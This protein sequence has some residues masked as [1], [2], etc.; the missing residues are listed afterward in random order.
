MRVNGDDMAKIDAFHVFGP[1]VL[2]SQNEYY[3]NAIESR[4]LSIV[5]QESNRTDIPTELDE[6]YEKRVENVRNTL[7]CLRHKMYFNIAIRSERVEGVS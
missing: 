3:D 1:K 2:A 7:T 6:K 4:C 5:M